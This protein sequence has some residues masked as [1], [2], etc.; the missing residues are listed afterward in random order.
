MD[1]Y[2]PAKMRR[3]AHSK[4]HCIKMSNNHYC[5]RKKQRGFSLIESMVTLFVLT[6]GILGVAGLQSISIISHKDSYHISQAMLLAQNLAERVRA[7]MGGV[8]LYHQHGRS[9]GSFA[10]QC[11]TTSGCSTEQMT[12]TD[13]YEWQQALNNLLPSGQGIICRSGSVPTAFQLAGDD[14]RAQIAG[15]CNDGGDTFVIHVFWDRNNDGNI[16]LKVNQNTINTASS[17]GYLQLVFTP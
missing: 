9:G 1:E 2:A 6:V 13:I 17:D 12:L 10:S 11:F 7:N 14:L 4:R 16:Q 3:Y 8:D 15:T 5:M